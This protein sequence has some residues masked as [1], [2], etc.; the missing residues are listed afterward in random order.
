MDS[1]TDIGPLITEKVA[2]KIEEIV[3]NAVSN[4]ARLFCGA[5]RKG[6]LYWPTVLD[7]V[8]PLSSIVMEETFGAL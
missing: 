2:I 4:G 5:K 6:T 8:D 3:N 7:Y 1:S